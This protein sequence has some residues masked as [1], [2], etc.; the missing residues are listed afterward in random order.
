MIYRKGDISYFHI[1]AVMLLFG[2]AG[3]IV[4]LILPTGTLQ[5]FTALTTAAPFALILL[6]PNKNRYHHSKDAVF[7]HILLVVIL[8]LVFWKTAWDY[9]HIVVYIIALFICLISFF[10]SRTE[11]LIQLIINGFFAM[12]IIFALFTIVCFFSRSF[13]FNYIINLFPERI[14]Y[15]TYLYNSGCIAGLTSHYSTNGMVLATGLVIAAAK[16]FSDNKKRNLFFCILFLITLLMTGKRAQLIFGIA[17]VFVLYYCSLYTRGSINRW[18]KT[19]GLIIIALCAITV[20]IT[21]VPSLSTFV[22]RF[23]MLS[24]SGD[25]SAERFELW[26]IAIDAFKKHPFIGIGWEQYRATLTASFSSTRDTHNV[27]LQ[28]LCETGILGALVYYSWFITMYIMTIRKMKMVV[29]KTGDKNAKFLIGFSLAF[30]TFFLMY[31][32][33]G[34]PLYEMYMFIPYFVS[35]AITISMYYNTTCRLYEV[36]N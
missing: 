4:M 23:Q 5:L 33:T 18:I 6:N 2:A 31:C 28:L 9:T 26:A 16:H 13:Y 29:C 25:V 7:L 20:L 15:L 22:V 30:Q 3:P 10:Y 19:L 11:Q 35:C 12:D 21:L 32:L 24:D 27:F 36:V 1:A 8:M 17:A 34:N 14:S